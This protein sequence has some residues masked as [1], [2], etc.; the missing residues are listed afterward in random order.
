MKLGLFPRLKN[1]CVAS[2]LCKQWLVN[3][4]RA[5]GCKGWWDTD[6]WELLGRNAFTNDTTRGKL[7]PN[8]CLISFQCWLVLDNKLIAPSDLGFFWLNPLIQRE[9]TD[10]SV[11]LDV[12]FLPHTWDS[13]RHLLVHALFVLNIFFQL[14]SS[15]LSFDMTLLQIAP[16][17]TNWR[18][19]LEALFQVQGSWAGASKHRLR[20]DP[21]MLVRV[22][23]ARV[24]GFSWLDLD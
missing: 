7:L 20:P 21:L 12:L 3:G 2:I 18:W 13:I 17:T 14:Y 6:S 4:N 22:S 10:A 19:P 11:S 1:G 23:R 5:N 24:L 9:G 8:K 15:T 16:P